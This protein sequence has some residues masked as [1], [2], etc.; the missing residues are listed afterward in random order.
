MIDIKDLSKNL[1]EILAYEPSGSPVIS[2]YLAVDQARIL[3]QEYTTMLNSLITGKKAE[4]ES[5]GMYSNPRKKMIYEM[6]ESIKLYINDYFRPESARTLLLYA[7]EGRVFSAVRL[8]FNLK[9]K[10]IID[11]KPHTQIL[12]SILSSARKYGILVVDREKAQILLMFMG[13][14]KEYLD[15][16]ISEVPAKVNFRSQMVF[17]EK[18]I[19]SRI[20]EKLHHF[21]KIINEKTMIHLREGKLDNIILAGR[22]DIISGFFNYLHRSIQEKYIGSILAEPDEPP[23][24][25]RDKAKILI[26]KYELDMKNK[27]VNQLIDNYYPQELGVLGVEATINSLMLD[28]IKTLIYNNSFTATGY[29]CSG[30]GYITM[31]KEDSCRIC[32]KGLTY[33]N[34]ITDEIIE[35]ALKQGCEI[36]D[37]EENDRLGQVGGIGAILRFKIEPYQTLSKTK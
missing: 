23:H 5:S 16:F 33:Y 1:D 17:R 3:K 6:M 8:P 14:I 26:D 4:I 37:V 15:A 25:I 19:L 31:E 27:I 35:S 20:E 7:K 2:L 32:S 9:S 18:N 28:Q 13:E 11:P 21:F 12:R 10:V 29:V 36:I 22:K 24:N 34:D 30:C